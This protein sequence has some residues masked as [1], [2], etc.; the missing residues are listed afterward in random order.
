MAPP[1]ADG[2]ELVPSWPALMPGDDFGASVAVEASG[3]WALVGAPGLSGRGAAF[4]VSIEA[5]AQCAHMSICSE[6]V[7]PEPTTGER[8][9]S[10]VAFSGST[11]VIG[12]D[13]A[14]NDDNVPIGAAYSFTFDLNGAMTLAHKFVPDDDPG[15]GRDGHFGCSVATSADRAF[16]GARGR[17]QRPANIVAFDSGAVYVFDLTTGA[18][19]AKVFPTDA[20][21]CYWFGAAL[22]VSGSQLVVG[23][24]RARS[25]CAS[26]SLAGAAYTFD[27]STFVQIGKLVAS[28]ASSRDEFGSAVAASQRPGGQIRVLVGAPGASNGQGAV[29][30]A[31]LSGAVAANGRISLPGESRLLG[32]ASQTG[33]GA[34]LGHSLAMQSA[35]VDVMIV[36]APQRFNSLSNEH[37]GL[38]SLLD[39][40]SF[41][42][43]REL[44]GADPYGLDEMGTSVAIGGGVT[45]VGAPRHCR[46]NWRRYEHACNASAGGGSAILLDL[47]L[48]P[49]P[50]PSPPSPSPL[51]PP[52]RYPPPPSPP[53]P[54]PESYQAGLPPAML[55]ALAVLGVVAI[56]FA[57][58]LLACVTLYS[59]FSRPPVKIK[60]RAMGIRQQ[61]EAAVGAANPA[62][63][64]V[65]HSKVTD[66][67][68]ENHQHRSRV[69]MLEDD[70]DEN[71]RDTFSESGRCRVLTQEEQ[72]RKEIAAMQRSL[73]KNEHVISRLTDARSPATTSPPA[74]TAPARSRAPQV[75]ELQRLEQMIEA[76]QRTIA[77]LY[78]LRNERSL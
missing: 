68:G 50:P 12:A 75:A 2:V 63:S 35:A 9:G 15:R 26:G 31:L 14:K 52:P 6:L 40:T 30:S 41:L 1:L 57:V 34:R 47:K 16:V 67:I 7:S 77:A 23:A 61:V 65:P 56:F 46:F 71:I 8:F 17:D 64:D 4:L 24:P 21:G 18:Q 66:V 3:T 27:A 62:D 76:N 43:S 48:S 42:E 70:H 49:P 13:G 28:D 20:Y 29:Y 58:V 51:T 33:T 54:P 36:G 45:L 69:T 72:L 19:L 60:P 73:Q 59:W 53:L 78:Q 38:A 32:P 74:S 11:F 22:A 55:T 5:T 39:P 25:P 37:S 10:A 44:Y